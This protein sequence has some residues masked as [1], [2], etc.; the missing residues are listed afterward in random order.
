M[1]FLNEKVN[2]LNSLSSWGRDHFEWSFN[3]TKGMQ[4]I[5][6][7]TISCRHVNRRMFDSTEINQGQF[8]S[9][10]CV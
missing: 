10:V 6:M 1:K 5:E 4:S 8:D 9:S 7:I 2:R 3:E